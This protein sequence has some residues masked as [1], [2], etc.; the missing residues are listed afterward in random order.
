MNSLNSWLGTSLPPVFWLLVAAGLA[1][2]VAILCMLAWRMI[3]RPHVRS[4][5]GRNRQPRL[6]VLDSYSVDRV[7]QL[8]LVRR[9]NVEHLIMIGGPNDLVVESGILRARPGAQGPRPGVGIPVPSAAPERVTGTTPRQ[10]EEEFARPVETTAQPSIRPV[11][12]VTTTPAPVAPPIG[13]PP[14]VVAPPVIAVQT[15]PPVTTPKPSVVPPREPG[16]FQRATSRFPTFGRPA[17]ATTPS[18]QTTPKA[19]DEEPRANIDTAHFEE[20]LAESDPPAVPLRAEATKPS[21]TEATPD[22]TTTPKFRPD[23][24]EFGGVEVEPDPTIS[25]P[26]PA[27]LTLPEIRLPDLKI[28]EWKRPEAPAAVE[29][30]PTPNPTPNLTSNLTPTPTPEPRTTAAPRSE[31][32]FTG[33]RIEPGVPT[34]STTAHDRGDGF[35]QTTTPRPEP[36]RVGERLSTP[37]RPSTPPPYTTRPLPPVAATTTPAPEP[38]DPFASLEEE[39]A[40]LLGRG[41]DDKKP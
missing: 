5:A 10:V 6:G 30:K 8:V 41:R 34:T 17:A 38:V 7:R 19:V 14:P 2:V 1:I 12:E 4:S 18:A 33:G 40:N 20:L 23:F 24:D 31:P 27:R 29:P 3:S 35:S 36:F 37:T 26:T 15:P 32:R 13:A 22:T 21:T 11:V 9:D 25:E 16:F 28:P 39:M